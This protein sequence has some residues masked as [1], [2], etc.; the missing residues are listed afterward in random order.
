MKFRSVTALRGNGDFRLL[1]IGQFT[2]ELGSSVAFVAT[3]LIAIAVT[4]STL[5]AGLLGSAAFLASWLGSVP[6]GYLADRIAPR[7]LMLWCDAVRL[8]VSAVLAVGVVAGFVSMWLL[9]VSG[10]VTTLAMLGF[11]PAATKMMRSIVPEDQI[12]TAVAANQLRGQAAALIGPALGGVLFQ[13]GR[14]IPL[15]TD[16]ASFALSLFCVGRL[17]PVTDSPQE[18][19]AGRRRFLPELGEG[20]RL[21][22][23]TPFLRS[24]T[25]YATLANIAVSILMFTII[26][27][28]GAESG[29]PAIGTALSVG[30]VAAMLG[31]LLAPRLHRRLGLPRLLLLITGVRVVTTA[32]AALAGGP[33][34]AIAALA[35]ILLL[36][37]VAATAT[38][39]ARIA[40]VPQH[41]YG[42][43]SGTSSFAGSALQP[44]APLIAGAVVQQAGAG[45]AFGIVAAL[46]TAAGLVVAVSRTALSV[47][48]P[49]SPTSQPAS[50]GSLSPLRSS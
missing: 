30:A 24:V 1:W 37:P 26:L 42:R 6:M 28:P 14:S 38:E 40:V 32:G 15:V 9:L 2:S 33:A 4:G 44:L 50:R 43:V 21:L 23:R 11:R 45:W 18:P 41:V 31:T 8:L 35:A 48:T 22:W 29:G 19:A 20:F 25:T 5:Q 34:A 36:Q 13:L 47:G 46:F 27:G 49:A 16:A 10:V 17:R 12:A 39:T 7:R 3:P